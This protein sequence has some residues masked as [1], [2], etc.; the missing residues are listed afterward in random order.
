MAKH[1]TRQSRAKT[2]KKKQCSPRSSKPCKK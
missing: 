1:V 2:G